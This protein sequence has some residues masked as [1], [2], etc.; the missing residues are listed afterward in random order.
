MQD[1]HITIIM[2]QFALATPQWEF[3]TVWPYLGYVIGM[4]A[5]PVYV[6]TWIILLYLMDRDSISMMI[7]VTLCLRLVYKCNV[8]VGAFIRRSQHNMACAGADCRLPLNGEVS[9]F[10]DGCM[11][12]LIMAYFMNVMATF[13]LTL[14]CV[15]MMLLT[16]F[17]HTSTLPF[18]VEL[19]IVVYV[20][21]MIG[22]TDLFWDMRRLLTPINTRP[23][24]IHT[25][26]QDNDPTEFFDVTAP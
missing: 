1:I 18:Y 19:L 20:G 25:L 3:K 24:P 11:I 14:G 22:S 9:Q 7:L 17:R 2:D 8:Y 26:Q 12:G 4:L 13:S 10:Y 6:Y 15:G 5:F 23:R 16:A 21:G